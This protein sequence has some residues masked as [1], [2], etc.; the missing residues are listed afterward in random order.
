[1]IDD[2]DDDDDDDDHDHDD[3]DAYGDD[4]AHVVRRMSKSFSLNPMR[5]HLRSSHSA[6]FHRILQ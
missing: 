5:E 2:D 4:D 3:G 6:P 1:M